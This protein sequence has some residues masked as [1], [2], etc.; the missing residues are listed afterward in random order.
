M[1]IGETLIIWLRGAARAASQTWRADG[2]RTDGPSVLRPDWAARRVVTRCW[3][4][5]CKPGTTPGLIAPD[6][7]A[8]QIRGALYNEQTETRPSAPLSSALKRIEDCFQRWRECRR[9]Y[10]AP[11]CAVPDRI[12]DRQIPALLRSR[13]RYA[14]F[15]RMLVSRTGWLNVVPRAVVT[16]VIPLR[17]ARSPNSATKLSRTA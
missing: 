16:E 3:S 15:L 9:R 11:R 14:R 4:D 17:R 13:S 12:G 6:T 1:L 10:R 2:G 7:V 5:D 8:E